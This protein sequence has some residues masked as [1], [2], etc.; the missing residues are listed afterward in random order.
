M[1]ENRFRKFSFFGIFHTCENKKMSFLSDF[2]PIA[3]LSE[4]IKL[5]KLKISKICFILFFFPNTPKMIC[6]NFFGDF[7]H[8]PEKNGVEKMNFEKN[9]GPSSKT[10]R[11]GKSGHP[12]PFTPLK[13]GDHIIFGMYVQLEVSTSIWHQNFV[14]GFFLSKVMIFWKK[15]VKKQNP[16]T[17]GGFIFLY[18]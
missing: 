13:R 8:F 5:Q 7:K 18:Q 12:P 4:A 9:R 6:S 10:V 15:V 2:C 3:S 1:E 14:S 17:L 11:G 16:K